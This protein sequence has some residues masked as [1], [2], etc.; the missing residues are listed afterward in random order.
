MGICYSAP[1]CATAG[2]S[3]Y[4]SATGA[5]GTTLTTNPSATGYPTLALCLVWDA[6]SNCLACNNGYFPTGSATA[7]ATVSTCTANPT[8]AAGL[9]TAFYIPLCAVYSVSKAANTCT[10][11]QAGYYPAATGVACAPCT[12]VTASCP[13]GAAAGWAGYAYSAATSAWVACSGS[14]AATCTY[15]GTT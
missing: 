3:N 10:A 11:C 13:F 1:A 4:L 5:C 15:S 8:G 14:N 9:T 6:N 2:S 12:G 7:A